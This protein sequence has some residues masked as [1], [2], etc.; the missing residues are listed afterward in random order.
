[1]SIL[2]ININLA[3][4]PQKGCL[5]FCRKLNE[6][7]FLLPNMRFTLNDIKIDEYFYQDKFKNDHFSYIFHRSMNNQKPS[8]LE[9]PDLDLAPL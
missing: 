3:D 2:N 6:N 1:M 9:Y 5:N 8:F 7:Y 4:H